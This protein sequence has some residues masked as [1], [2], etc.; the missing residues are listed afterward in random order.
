MARRGVLACAFAAL[1]AAGPVLAG[2]AAAAV[3]SRGSTAA[4]SGTL[5][6][7]TLSTGTGAA[8]TSRTANSRATAAAPQHVTIGISSVSP[9]I[10]QPG[11]AVTVQGTVAN[12]TRTTVNSLAVQLWS[13]TFKLTSR[14]ELSEYAAGNVAN[15]DTPISGALARLPGSL[16]PGAVRPWSIRVPASSLGLTAFGV[17]P[18]AAEVNAGGTPVTADHT[19]L[20]FWPEPRPG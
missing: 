8:V 13:S 17:Y 7:G 12:P 4:T 19:F 2:S 15:V 3:S 16:A 10:A 18:L 14:T 20:P 5:S 9:Q 6:T 1:M 11:R